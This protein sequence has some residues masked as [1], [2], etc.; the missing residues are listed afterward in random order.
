MLDAFVELS[1]FAGSRWDLVQAGGGN[2]SVKL[3]DGSMCVKASGF[4]LS[5]VKPGHGYSIV[6]NC[7]VLSILEDPAVISLENRRLQEAMASSLLAESLKPDQPKPSIETFMHALMATFT[8][9]THPI[10]VNA[11]TARS[12]WDIILQGLFPEALTVGYRTPGLALALELRDGLR[13]YRSRTMQRPAVVFLQNHGLIV[14]SDDPRQVRALTE[15]VVE[16]LEAFLGIDLS[17]Y[18]LSTRLQDLIRELGDMQSIVYRV[19]EG[20]WRSKLAAHET[21]LASP[22]CPDALVYCGFSPLRVTD[23]EDPAPFRSYRDRFL[24]W[25]KVVLYKEETLIIA[26][27]IRKA[28][29][30][31]EVLKFMV[32]VA[33]H[34]GE[35]LS[36]L[37]ASELAY[38]A[39]W[40]AEKHRRSR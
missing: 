7:T 31:E 16:R 25:P 3:E 22:F 1:K 8:L 24:E 40:D 39:N 17:P 14:S 30:I 35:G 21:Q 5:E 12:D 11:V 37:D 36:P 29:E 34:A 20:P 27:N 18:K 4:T 23:L 2:S 32:L 28:R 6:N 10:A 26:S 19:E 15:T 33:E 38:L 9:H 13:A